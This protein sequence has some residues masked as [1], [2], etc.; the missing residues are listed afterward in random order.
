MNFTIKYK[1]KK[2]IFL[3]IVFIS[4]LSLLKTCIGSLSSSVDFQWFPTTLVFKGINH[5]KYFIEGGNRFL[6]QNGEYGHG[7]YILLYPFSLMSFD[8]AKIFWMLTNSFFVFLIPV[9]LCKKFKVDTETTIIIVCIFITCAPT[10]AAINLGQQ[11]LFTMFFLI[12]P[13]I[14]NKK[15][16][17]ILSGFSYFKYSI[18]YGLAIFFLLKK[19]YKFFFFSIIPSLLGYLI[20]SILTNTSLI[21]SLFYPLKLVLQN[22]FVMGQDLYSI[23]SKLKLFNEFYN[24][25][26]S[27]TIVALINFYFLLK[28]K[29]IEDHLL[30]VS[31]LF[32]SILVF[33]PHANYDYVLLLPLLI[34]SLKNIKHN[35][36]NIM[37]LIFYFYF[38]KI[39]KHILGYNPTSYISI[40]DIFIFFLF[41]ICLVNN[42]IKSKKIN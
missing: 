23:L 31:M 35:K 28:I 24:N 13:F 42:L 4:F 12:L 32:L 34:Y 22:K 27:I 6:A 38:S 2:K 39:I 21:D 36:F 30:Q 20:Y 40:Y 9:L 3:F 41:F 37:I 1:Y 18:G 10:R 14:S 29:M 15:G 5:Y 8:I 26:F 33:S 16:L 17:I 19:K 11:S 25:F 7:L